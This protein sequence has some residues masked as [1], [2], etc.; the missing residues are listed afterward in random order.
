MVACIFSFKYAQTHAYSSKKQ[1]R[2]HR[3]QAS[4]VK[5]NPPFFTNP[6]RS[7]PDQPII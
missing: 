7:S 6:L 1:T 4:S 5:K 3:P 2:S